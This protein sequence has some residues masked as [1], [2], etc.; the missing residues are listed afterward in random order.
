MDKGRFWLLT[1]ESPHP[2]IVDVA[3][4]NQFTVDEL[5]DGAAVQFVLYAMGGCFCR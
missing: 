5:V 1:P 2:S 3:F 4:F